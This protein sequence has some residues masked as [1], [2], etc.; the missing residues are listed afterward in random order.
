MSERRKKYRGAI[1]VCSEDKTQ[2]FLP[3]GDDFIKASSEA[4]AK[5]LIDLA[6]GS[7]CTRSRCPF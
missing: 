7:I 1:I 4:D 5:R 6:L 2:F 3:R